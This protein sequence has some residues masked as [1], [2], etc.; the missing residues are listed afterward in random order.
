M[1]F[2]FINGVCESRFESPQICKW[3]VHSYPKKGPM[4]PNL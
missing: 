2:S 4:Q 1:S 3:E